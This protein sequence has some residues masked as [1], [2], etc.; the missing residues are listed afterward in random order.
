MDV[1]RIGDHIPDFDL[2]VSA[3]QRLS[4]QTRH[5]LRMVSDIAYGPTP[6]QKL[7][8][9]F[10]AGGGK[11]LPV[12]MFVHGGYWRM[13]SKDDFSHVANTISAAGAIAVVIDFDPMPSVRLAEVVRQVRG[14][15]NWI[16]ENISQYG[17]DAERLTVSGHSTGAHLATFL[18]TEDQTAQPRGS[19]LLGGIYNI[20]ALQ[21]SF[22]QPLVHLTDEEVRE[23]CPLR[24]A[25]RP[26]VDSFILYGEQE[27]QSGRA[28]GGA[29]AW[30]LKEAGCDVV[31]AALSDASHI[32][33]ILDLGRPESEAGRYLCSLIA[34]Y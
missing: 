33:S 27:A 34:R 25:F 32:S 21:Q 3:C 2:K 26:R 9:F 14:A 19:L 12:H 23:F 10:P 24:R 28:Q 1:F 11:N 20:G 17:G 31:L 22:L 8:I 6:G 7:D 29:L 5:S 4:A 18:F 30:Q 16:V 13:F 15:R